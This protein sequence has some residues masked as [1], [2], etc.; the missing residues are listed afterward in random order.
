MKSALYIGRVWH[1][2]SSG[3]AHS[4]SY[5]HALL[6]L[7]LDELEHVFDGRW[8]WSVERANVA[9]FRRADYFGDP[10][11]PLADAVRARVHQELGREPRGPVR[12]F[13]Q[14]R[15]LGYVLNPVSF[16]FCYASDGTQLEAI[17]AEITNT[18]WNERHAYVIDA[19][20]VSEGRVRARFPKRFHVSPFQPMEHEYEWEIG[21]PGDELRV[22][23]RNLERGACVFRADMQLERKPLDGANLAR[24]LALLPGLSLRTS[25]AIYFQALRLRLK[26]APVFD[27]PRTRS[28][29]LARSP[30]GVAGG[31]DRR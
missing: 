31:V 23:M 8:L 30:A 14:P 19:R 18:P 4:F 20:H 7:D 29:A 27:H 1:A 2:R 21:E 10:A 25:A 17:L 12:L 13:A 26:G 11:V 22:H 28:T 16:Y 9:S 3:V 5:R 15:L 6:C 24:L